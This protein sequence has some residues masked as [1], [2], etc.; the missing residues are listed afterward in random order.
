MSI[1][2]NAQRAAYERD[3]AAIEW[4][5]M[6][7]APAHRTGHRERSVAGALFCAVMEYCHA[8]GATSVGGVMETF[9]LPRWQRFGWTTRVLGL[10]EDIAGCMTLAAFMD[11]DRKALDGVRAAT[12][13]RDSVLAWREAPEDEPALWRR[14]YSGLI[15]QWI[16]VGLPDERLL[17]RAAGRAAQV[18]VYAYSERQAEVW[19]QKEG[20][21]MRR[22]ENLR[23]YL[24]P[25]D[26]A[27][28]ITDMCERTMQ[29]QCTLQDGE[30]WLTN[31][32][33]TVQIHL[34]SLMPDS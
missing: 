32:A 34:Q 26:Q 30:V 10:P 25:D 1:L 31:G 4:T 5:R 3:P 9:W 2:T 29:L 7:V 17:R 22:I 12:G 33:Q 23:V 27:Q 19:W 24:L 8:I 20:S 11:V 13:W 16:E 18:V 6:F 14:D 15:E 21:V 28:A